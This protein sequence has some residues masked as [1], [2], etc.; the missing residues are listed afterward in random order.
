MHMREFFHENFVE[1]AVIL[2]NCHK[3]RK[4][5]KCISIKGIMGR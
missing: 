2:L 5:T 1:R 3:G 4:V